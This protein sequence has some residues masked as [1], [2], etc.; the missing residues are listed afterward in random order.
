[1]K[2]GKYYTLSEGPRPVI[3]LP[4]DYH[5]R[6]T[7]VVRT[8]GDP[9]SLLAPVRR[10]VQALDPDVVP[11]D[12]ETMKQYMAL[13]LFPAHTTGLLLGAFGTLALVLAITG[14]YGVVSYSVSQRTHE[15]G[16]R[17]ALGAGARDVL[18]L[19]VLQGLR[20]TLVGVACGLV[21]AYAVTRVLSS[22]LY[23]IR[24]TDA[25]T[26]AGVSLLLTG[27]ALIASYI[28]ARRAMK[29]DPTLALRHE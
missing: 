8:G 17:M 23:G 10:E 16:V 25:L 29:V 22:L 3:Y 15:I 7:L 28:P 20:P 9:R 19:A 6:A 12:L 21:G 14:L 11:I 5:S 24:P 13:P 18:K 4:S 27:V 1:V 2:T 26:F